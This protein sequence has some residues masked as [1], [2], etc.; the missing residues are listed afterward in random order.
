MPVRPAG[1]GWTLV[2]PITPEFSILGDSGQCHRYTD[3]V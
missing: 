3:Y 1:E 2:T